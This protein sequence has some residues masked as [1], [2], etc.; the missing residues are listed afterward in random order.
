MFMHRITLRNILSFGPDAQELALKPLNVFIGPN[1]SGKS[2]LIDAIGL[3]Q[4][5]STDAAKRVRESGG[6]GDWIWRGEPKAP[7]ARVEIVTPNPTAPRLLRYRFEFAEQGQAFLIVHERLADEEPMADKEPWV[8]F[9]ADSRH[10]TIHRPVTDAGDTEPVFNTRAG[11][12]ESAAFNLSGQQSVFAL[13][14]DPNNHPEIT[15]LGEEFSRIRL[16]RDLHVGREA[17]VRFPQKPDFPNDVLAEDGRNLALV[18][19][20]LNRSLDVKRRFLEALRKLYAGLSD[21]HVNIE[22][23]TVQV[24]ITGGQ[25]LDTRDTALRRYAPLPL[26]ARRSLRPASAAARVHRGAGTGPAPGHPAGARG[27]A[28]RCLRALSTARDNPLRHAR[29]CVDGDA[30]ERGRLREARRPDT[31]EAPERRWPLGM[32]GA[33]PARR[34]L[35]LRGYR[36]ESLVNVTVYVEGGGS[37]RVTKKRCR[38]GFSALFSKAGLSGRMPRIFA[39]G[40]G[41]DAWRDFRTALTRAGEDDFHRRRIQPS[42]V[43]APSRRRERLETRPGTRNESG[44]APVQQGG[45]PQ[46]TSLVRDSRRGGPGQG[47]CGVASC[48]AAH[49]HAGRQVFLK[50]TNRCDSFS[51]SACPDCCRFRPT[52]ISSTCSR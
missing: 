1:G 42:C 5:A 50:G 11:D 27:A 43:A 31:H 2:N 6:V 51:D 3:L 12:T 34:I 39:A 21:F 32:A 49:R 9:D 16:Y 15:R 7:S 35:G 10:A 17:P 19:N 4:V 25:R 22:Y 46:G 18:L 37:V 48:E 33:V 38:Q 20:R 24:F 13:L 14:K 23:G 45:V 41:E 8:W 28:A 30:G 36:R 40:S 44:A 29:R 47:G 26:S 52:W